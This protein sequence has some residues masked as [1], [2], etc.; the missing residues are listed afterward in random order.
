MGLQLVDGKLVFPALMV[1]HDQFF[2]GVGRCIQERRQQAMHLFL[3]RATGVVQGVFD[4][5]HQDAVLILLAVVRRGV[6]LGQ[7]RAIGQDLDGL[8]HQIAF[9]TGQQLGLAL[10]DLLQRLVAEEIAV[11][12]QQHALLQPAQQVIGHGDFANVDGLD[13]VA[14]QHVGAGFA[15]TEDAGLWV[16]TLGAAGLGLAKDTGVVGAVG[17]IDDEAI[18]SH[19]AQAVVKRTGRFGGAQQT[20]DRAGEI[21]Q[22]GHPQAVA[23]LAEG[24]AAGR[25][26]AAEAL[27]VLVD[28]RE[29]VGGEQSQ[30]NDQPDNEPGRQ[31]L[32]ASLRMAG[33]HQD[34]LNLRAWD[35]TLQG[36]NTLIGGQ[37]SEIGEIVIYVRHGDLLV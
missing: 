1:E 8:E 25:T 7:I 32:V 23:S 30:T 36:T 35:D 20:D 4:D 28:L 12:Q 34:C 10:L 18:Q 33:S 17:N 22:D 13:Q 11:P 21:T 14:V 37:L 27:Q 19:Q 16:G 29:R 3:G 9:D 24:A 31:D 6:H 2:G 26:A 5:A 15:Q